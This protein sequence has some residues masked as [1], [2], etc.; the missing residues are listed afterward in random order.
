VDVLQLNRV[1]CGNCLVLMREMPSESVDLVLTSPPYWGLR[2]YSTVASRSGPDRAVVEEALKQSLDHYSAKYPRYRYWV[3]GIAY[4]E[5]SAI[6]SGSVSVDLSTVWGGR[7]DC[8]HEWVESKGGL[9]HENRNNLRGSQEEVVGQTGTA[10]IRKYDVVIQGT[11]VK[12]GAWRGQLGLEP[13]PQTYVEHLV[14]ICREIRR[15]LKKTGSLYLVLGDTYCSMA[16]GS[17]NPGGDSIRG[18]EKV[19]PESSPNR[20]VKSDGGLLQ[21]KQ[22]LLIPSRVAIALQEDGWV[23][24]DKI[25]WRKPNAM[26]GSQRDR[27]TRSY[28]EIFHFVK[29][30]GRALLWRNELTGEWVDMKPKQRYFK[31]VRAPFNLRVRDVKRGKGGIS[32]FGELKASKEEVE[33]Y[34]YPEK[35]PEFIEGHEIRD[36]RPS[37]EGLIWKP[38]WRGFDYYYDLDVIREPHRSAGRYEKV[39]HTVREGDVHKRTFSKEARIQGLRGRTR[40]EESLLLNPRGKN[41]GD[42]LAIAR[43]KGRA[44]DAPQHAKRTRPSDIDR[45]VYSGGYYHEKGKNPGDVVFSRTDPRLIRDRPLRPPHHPYR[46]DGWEG[47][48]PD[49]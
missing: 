44:L 21:P 18:I 19:Q 29:N 2:D 28:E 38:L 40:Y 46:G 14:E 25:I 12:C 6:Y 43:R 5:Q 32:S 33:A 26:P 35:K 3:G 15:V 22:L 36:T 7:Q 39:P 34:S 41:P 10:W 24:R 8:A 30:T 4:S 31:T 23:L 1:H 37:K 48:N 49:M 45:M 20:M 13:R 16:G 11:C 27:L 9:V 42:V 47:I 17:H